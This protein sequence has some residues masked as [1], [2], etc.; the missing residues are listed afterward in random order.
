MIRL[1]LSSLLVVAV[2]A[3]GGSSDPVA[4]GDPANLTGKTKLL[5]CNVFESGGGPD[6]QV[7]ILRDD[8]GKLTLRELTESGATEERELA[9]TEWDAKNIALRKE[10]PD[11]VNTLRKEGRD[12]INEAKG[13]GFHAYGYADCA[14]DKSE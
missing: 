10:A 7:T 9:R 5:D 1:V 4:S 12:W 11:D 3:C 2:A 6:Q 14:T 8:T 13:G